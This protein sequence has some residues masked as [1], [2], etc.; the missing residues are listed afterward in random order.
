MPNIELAKDSGMQVGNGII[1]D[2]YLVTS[3]PNVFAAG[4]VAEFF[5][6][7]L[8]KRLR[9][10]HED[11][12]NSMGR[13]AGRNIA[14]VSEP[15]HHLPFFYSDLFELGYEAVGGFKWNQFQLSL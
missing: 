10:E 15:Y 12:A 8:G 4:D 9:F 13:Q 2:E 11:N 14:G 6:P 5:N 1:V 7:T 3:H